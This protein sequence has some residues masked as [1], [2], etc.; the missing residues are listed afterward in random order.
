M[1][2]FKNTTTDNIVSAWKTLSESAVTISD[3]ILHLPTLLSDLKT[4]LEKGIVERLVDGPYRLTDM[5]IDTVFGDVVF[6]I[7]F[8]V[9]DEDDLK[10]PIRASH[11]PHIE[12]K[13]K[14]Y[15]YFVFNCTQDDDTDD[16]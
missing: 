3:G 6:D 16:F 1:D 5:N 15:Q 13:D 12:Y 10:R 9:Q 14:L 2:I 4:S 8:R 11:L 7:I